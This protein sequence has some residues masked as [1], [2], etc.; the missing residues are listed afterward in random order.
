M[1]IVDCVCQPLMPVSSELGRAV[2]GLRNR[3]GVAVL[4][5]NQVSNLL[6]TISWRL[7]IIAK[8]VF[9]R[10]IGH[11]DTLW[12]HGI[13]GFEVSLDVQESGFL[14]RHIQH[15]ILITLVRAANGKLKCQC[16]TVK[17]RSLQSGV[18]Q[19]MNDLGQLDKFEESCGSRSIKVSTSFV[20]HILE[21]LRH[22]FIK[23][24]I[25]HG[26]L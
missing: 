7:T 3:L 2:H 9:V 10:G 18:Q 15:G 17:V 1:T 20:H 26:Q 13:P 23:L 14:S 16:L 12:Y 24:Q 22:I 21:N 5:H 4:A 6:Y 19:S 11:G 25:V 8:T